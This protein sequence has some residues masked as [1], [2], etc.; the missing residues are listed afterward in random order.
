MASADR[1]LFITLEGGEGSGKST[2]APTLAKRLRERGYRVCLTREPGGTSR[3]RMI[4]AIFEHDESGNPL[5]PLAEL[6]L[7]EADRTQH[8][9]EQILPALATD[10]IVVCDR[11]IDSSLA[12]QGFGRGVDLEFVR[13]LNDATTGGLKPQLTLL[14][15]VPPEAGLARAAAPRDAT[16][17]ESLEFHTRVRE[18]FLELAKDEPDRFVI[19]DATLPFEVVAHQSVT[20]VERLL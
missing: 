18:G 4:Q 14:L 9:S 11:F 3:G 12:Y 16:G 5:T 17:R 1:G 20:A 15:D 2:L 7:F 8:V 10:D 19:I 13:A 6:L